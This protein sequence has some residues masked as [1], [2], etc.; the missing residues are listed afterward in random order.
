MKRP[1]YGGR[2]NRHL[3]V[4]TQFFGTCYK[5]YGVKIN[6]SLLTIGSTRV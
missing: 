1:V 3:T 4:L 6:G 2:F 5:V